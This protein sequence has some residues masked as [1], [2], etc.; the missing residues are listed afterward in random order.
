MFPQLI[1]PLLPQDDKEG[2]PSTGAAFP[3]ADVIRKTI[4]ALLHDCR[5]KSEEM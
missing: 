2:S 1:V 5:R 4:L 3:T